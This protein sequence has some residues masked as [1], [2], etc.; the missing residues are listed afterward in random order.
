MTRTGPVLLAALV[1]IAPLVASAPD[2]SGSW[3]TTID[4]M[5]GPI[6]YTY[7]FKVDGTK[8]T[9]TATTDKT[10]V[11]IEQGRVEGEALSFLENRDIEGLGRTHIAYTCKITSAD[12][13]ACHREVGVIAS[14]D[15]IVER[16]K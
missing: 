4:T 9:G 16:L 2:I 15:F 3:T 14:E 13:L 6:A 11:T 8:L 12:A 10:P 5:M 1:L 7:D